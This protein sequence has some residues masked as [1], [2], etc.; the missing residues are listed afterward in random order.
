MLTF[1][2]AAGAGPDDRGFCTPSEFVSARPRGSQSHRGALETA[3]STSSGI[4][5]VSMR[6]QNDR[7]RRLRHAVVLLSQPA[8]TFE[9]HN[10]AVLRPTTAGFCTLDRRWQPADVPWL[11]TQPTGDRDAGL[12]TRPALRGVPDAG[13]RPATAER[14][15]DPSGRSGRPRSR[16]LP[17]PPV[18]TGL[19]RHL[20][21][22]V[23]PRRPDRADH[24]RS[25]RAEPPTPTTGRDGSQRGQPRPADRRP[26]R[27]R[28]WQRRFLGR[29]R[30]SRRPSALAGSG[31]GRHRGGDLDHPGRVGGR[32][33]RRRARR[34]RALSRRGRET[35]TRT[36]PRH[37]RLDRGVQAAHAPPHGTFRR[38]L[39]TVPR[40]PSRRSR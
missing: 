27:A 22:D 33:A 26:H 38:R 36:G 19:P 23:V 20:D 25:E 35:R 29:D 8:R 17:G 6:L 13:E 37:R 15:A 7:V 21:A 4:S 9:L 11:T 12:R 28:P 5:V 24:P 30:G 1:W 10:P 34:R 40:L 18:P 2:G 31:G 39:A 16:H 3:E 14:A 32:R